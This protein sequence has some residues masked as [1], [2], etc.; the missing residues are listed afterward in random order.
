MCAYIYIYIYTSHSHW[1]GVD[2]HSTGHNQQPDQICEGD[3]ALREANGG[4]TRYWL[5][6]WFG[7]LAHYS[8]QR[9]SSLLK[10]VGICLNNRSHHM[11]SV[12]VS[13]GLRPGYRRTLILFFS[14]VLLLIWWCVWDHCPVASPDLGHAF[15]FDSRIQKSLWSTQWLWG[16]QVLWLRRLPIRLKLLKPLKTMKWTLNKVPWFRWP[17]SCKHKLTWLTT[18]S[19]RTLKH[20]S[21]KFSPTKL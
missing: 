12:R 16:A 8:L 1:R 11:I 6:F 9:C 4:H 2:Q 19:I 7:I 15:A 13:S 21:T 3:V 20:P 18:S 5:V 10:F 14:A 17:W